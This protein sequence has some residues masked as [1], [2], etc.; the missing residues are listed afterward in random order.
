MG[1]CHLPSGPLGS[2]R[3]IA[4]QAADDERFAGR[5][6]NFLGENAQLVDLH[7]APRLCEEALDEAEVAAGDACDG[8]E[9]FGVCEIAG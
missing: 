3:G 2:P 8:G 5:L 7:N 1:V 4:L 6:D 9:R